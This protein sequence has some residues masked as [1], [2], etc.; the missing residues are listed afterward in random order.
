MKLKT[1]GVDVHKL[2]DTSLETVEHI[3]SWRQYMSI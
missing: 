2:N 3:S 1:L